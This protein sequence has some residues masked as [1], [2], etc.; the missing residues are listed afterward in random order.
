MTLQFYLTFASV[1]SYAHPWYMG[2]TTDVIFKES[3]GSGLAHVAQIVHCKSVVFSSSAI[4]SDYSVCSLWQQ[5]TN[6][7]T[8]ADVQ[9]VSFAGQG[10]LVP[11]IVTAHDSLHLLYMGYLFLWNY[12]SCHFDVN[13]L[14]FAIFSTLSIRCLYPL[15]YHF[16][17]VGLCSWARFVL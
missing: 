4:L 1:K 6:D 7:R 8:M 16:W 3:F 17:H 13:L 15:M 14:P 12:A 9:L 11:L 5:E 10:S 2:N